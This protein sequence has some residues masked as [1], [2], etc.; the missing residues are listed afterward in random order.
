MAAGRAFSFSYAEHAEMLRAAGAQVAEFDPLT[1]QLPASASAVV[2]PGGFPEQY[3]AELSANTALRQGIAALAQHGPV[4][5]ECAGLTYLMTDLDGHEMCGVLHG[6]ARFTERLTL[7]Y[8]NAVAVTDSPVHTVGDRV[9][10]HEFHRTTVDFGD[11]YPPAWMYRMPDA[12]VV[13]DGAV[14]GGVHASY[15]HTHPAAAP[16]ADPALRLGCRCL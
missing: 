2:L 12:T 5:A 10:G 1:E 3:P 7:G 14:L 11:E 16:Q 4:Y 9:V 6:S 8:R 15:L 13:R